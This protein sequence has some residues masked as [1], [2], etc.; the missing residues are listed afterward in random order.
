MTAPVLGA[1]MLTIALHLVTSGSLATIPEGANKHEH[2]VLCEVLAIVDAD[3]DIPPQESVDEASYNKIRNLNFSTSTTD[4]R[5]TFYSDDALTKPHPEAQPAHKKIADYAKYWPDWHGAATALAATKKPDE[6]EKAK[7]DELTHQSRQIA[8]ARVRAIA[9]T[10]RAAKEKALQTAGEAEVIDKAEELKA[11][12]TVFFGADSA[13]AATVTTTNAF[14]TGTINARQTACEAD[15]ADGKAKTLVAQLMCVCTKATQGSAL[16]KACTAAADGSQGWNSGSGSPA[17][18]DASAVAKTCANTGESKITATRLRQAITNV[19][20]LVHLTSDG[21]GYIG[22]YQATGC[23]GAD[24]AGM[25]VKIPNYKSNPTDGIKKLQWTS[26]LEN[27]ANKLE[28]RTR[29]N[30]IISKLNEQLRSSSEQAEET[31]QLT[32][33]EEAAR[34][35]ATKEQTQKSTTATQAQNTLINECEKITK[36]AQCKEKKPACEWQNKAAEDGPHCKLNATNVEQQATQ[37][38]TGDGAAA[39]TT[40]K[41]GAA[42]TPEECAAVKGEI[43][44]D[45]KAV[46]GWIEGKCQDSSIIINKKFALSVVSAAFMALL[47]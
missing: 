13:A 3:L 43:P 39:T 26:T 12:K 42:K 40:D 35:T 15:P 44:K 10:A 17:D 45:K 4:W 25:C 33:R 29:Y 37:A 28:A 32:K 30:T 11:L 22:V 41:C 31:I 14:G 5:K 7:L 20:K 6:V 38:G 27:L 47:F 46:C 8:H 24:N 9:E 21:T 23:T 2:A 36:A 34:S 16:S 18:T 1:T 19:A